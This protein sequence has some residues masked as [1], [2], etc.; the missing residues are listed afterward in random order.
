[1]DVIDFDEEE[2][3]DPKKTDFMSATGNLF[4]AINYK[5]FIFVFL[6]GIVIFSNLFIEKI[7]VGFNNAVEGDEPTSWGTT[8][9]LLMLCIAM[10]MFDV[11]IDRKVL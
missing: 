7:L 11:L 2:K 1:M 10:I 5:L 4:C 3:A 6:T 9:Q 8:L